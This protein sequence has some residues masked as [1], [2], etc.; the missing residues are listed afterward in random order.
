MK[1]IKIKCPA[2]INLDLRVFPKADNGFHPIKSIMQAINLFDYLTIKIKDGSGIFLSG[3]SDE[4][5]YDDKNLCHKAARLFL[6]RIKNNFTISTISITSNNIITFSIYY[7][8][9][10]FINLILSIN[11]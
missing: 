6:E 2:K 10:F 7:K 1:Q 5:P 11:I 8:I 3:T 4:I 9:T